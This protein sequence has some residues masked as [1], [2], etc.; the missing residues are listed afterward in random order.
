MSDSPRTSRTSVRVDAQMQTD[1]SKR[2]D[3]A[4]VFSTIHDLGDRFSSWA[5][6]DVS[7]VSPTVLREKGASAASVARAKVMFFH[8]LLVLRTAALVEDAVRSLNESRLVSFALATRGLL[9][10]AAFAAYHCGKLGMTAEAVTLPEDYEERLRAAVFASR[11]DWLRFFT[12]HVARIALVDAYDADP[13]KQEPEVKAVNPITAL[14]ALGARLKPQVEKARGI[15]HR[16]YALLSDICHPSAGSQLLFFAG[17]EPRMK[18]DLVPPRLTVVG[19][20]EQLLPCLA[21]S[22]SVVMEVL[23]DLE[24]ID[25]RLGKLPATAVPSPPPAEG[26]SASE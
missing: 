2:P 15:V 22:M 17:S 3:F 7:V 13:R 16:D 25:E 21:Y 9:E 10:T 4:N 5:R 1:L 19:I 6:S 14:D 24:E 18:A 20:A 26:A 11:F 12:D 8:R 23:A